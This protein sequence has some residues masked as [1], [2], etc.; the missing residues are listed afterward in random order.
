MQLDVML[1]PVQDECTELYFHAERGV[2]CHAGGMR[3]A[4]GCVV[5]F[6]G[7]YNLFPI[8]TYRKYTVC[9]SPQLVLEARGRGRVMLT[10]CDA[11]GN[12]LLEESTSVN[13]ENFCKVTA[14]FGVVV[15]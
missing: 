7:Y 15:I 10:A 4:G 5:S 6:D 14:G 12:V 9:T 2:S 1:L 8:G 3:L 11:Q 13:A